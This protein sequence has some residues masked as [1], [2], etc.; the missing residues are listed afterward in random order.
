[1]AAR[2]RLRRGTLAEIAA[3]DMASG[4]LCFATDSKQVIASDG[5]SKFHVSGSSSGLREDRPSASL[6]GRIYV[7]TDTHESW[8]DS[9]TA[10][11]PLVEYGIT[12]GTVCEGDDARLSDARTPTSHTHE[13]ADIT[14]L[15]TYLELVEGKAPTA[16]LGSGTADN[17]VFLRGDQTW[18]SPGEIAVPDASMLVKGKIQLAGDLGGTAAAPEVSHIHSGETQLSISTITDGQFLKRDGVNIVSQ[19]I[20]PGITTGKAIAMSIVF[21]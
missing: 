14:D 2:I 4:E 8:L 11:L 9:G 7:A 3:S 17:S 20:V 12:E 18:S 16:T 21:G 19:S 6:A 10:W 13:E 5:T 15:G 1:M